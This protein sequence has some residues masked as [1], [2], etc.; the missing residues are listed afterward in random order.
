MRNNGKWVKPEGVC[1]RCHACPRVTTSNGL[2]ESYCRKCMNLNARGKYRKNPEN[3]GR[4]VRKSELKMK[5]G[6]T[7]ADKE[8]MFEEQGR[9]CAACGSSEV[10][11]KA[12]KRKLKNPWCLDHNHTTNKIRGIL[13]YWCNFTIGNAKE[14]VERLRAC[15]VY[16]ERH[17]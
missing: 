12:K 4:I 5:Y 1:C 10:G 9:K 8:R 14:S 2:V 15:A 16:L 17:L 3:I 7:Y 11:F 6:I 13:C